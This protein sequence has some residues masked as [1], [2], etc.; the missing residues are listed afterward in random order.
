[1]GSDSSE[2]GEHYLE[3]LL[4][5]LDPS[6]ATAVER[7]AHELY[8]QACDRGLHDGRGAEPLAAACVYVACRTVGATVT[9]DERDGPEG[10]A[11]PPTRPATVDGLAATAPQPGSG[12]LFGA[13]ALR[14]A[15]DALAGEFEFGLPLRDAT[16]YLAGLVARFDV[17]EPV[18]Q[19]ATE[20][21]EEAQAAGLGSSAGR[22]P[23][24][25]AGAALVVA[26]E[27]L[28]GEGWPFRIDDVVEAIEPTAMTLR[29]RRVELRELVGAG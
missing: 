11:E 16:D 2:R 10:E 29:R 21:I 23:E 25:L 15:V 20:L 19:R 22:H 1:L 18:E 17:A 6:A 9:V 14:R 4:D 7:Q 27:Q 13:S 5:R 26:H 28:D 8:R 3:D 12:T 24:A